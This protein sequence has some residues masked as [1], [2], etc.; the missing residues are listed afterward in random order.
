MLSIQERKLVVNLYDKGKKQEE[1]ADIIGCSQP[2][3]HFW[4]NNN[5]KGRTLETLP[6]SGRPTELTENNLKKLKKKIHV[7]IK[8]R[9]E[10]Y[11]STSTKEVRD[12]IKQEIKVTYSIRHIERLMHKLGFSLITPRPQHIKHSQD[13]VDKF[14]DDFK[15]NSNQNIWVMS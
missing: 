1:I 3:V 14:R 2:T 8:E 15:K 9:N 12:I 11:N 6:K 4:I 10:E 7:I 13:K 5:K